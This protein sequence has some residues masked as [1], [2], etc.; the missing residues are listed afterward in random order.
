MVEVLED[1]ASVHPA[2]RAYTFIDSFGREEATLTFGELQARVAGLAA[3]LATR[4]APGQRALLIF[5]TCAEFIVTFLACLRAGVVAVPMSSPRRGRAAHLAQGIA[6]RSGAAAVLTTSELL[7]PLQAGLPLESLQWIASDVQTKALGNATAIQIN[8]RFPAFLQFTSGSTSSPKGVMVDHH[9]LMANQEVMYQ[10]FEH[11]DLST[12]VGWAPLF[13]DQGL[14]GNVL[15]PMFAGTTCVLMAPLA[16]VKRPLAWLKAISDHRA[17]TSGGPNFAFDLC[18]RQATPERLR[19]LALDLSCWTVAFNGAEPIRPDTIDRFSRT[20]EPYG[21]RRE[22]FMPCY[23]LAEGTLYV[24]GAPKG[25]GPITRFV[26]RQALRSGQVRSAQPDAAGTQ[27]LVGSGMARFGVD[28]RIVDPLTRTCRPRGQVGE[29]WVGGN[30]VARGYW[31]DHEATATVF[32]VPL[33][34]G[35]GAY[36]RTGDLGFL[37]ADGELFVTGRIKDLIIVMGRNHYPQDIERSMEGSH[38]AL[39]AGA[40]VA[41]GVDVEGQERL[42]LVQELLRDD[43]EKGG[44]DFGALASAIRRAVVSN[45]DLVPHA[46]GL[47]KAGTIPKTTSGKVQRQLLRQW[48]LAG[49]LAFEALFSSTAPAED[50]THE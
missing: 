14:I 39:R 34:D 22:A 40:G 23:G 3:H 2:R 6:A 20:F 41:F 11:N 32:Q 50:V 31:T 19:D 35:T 44:M 5:P 24:T 16:F 26:E 47:V 9:N 12:V 18:V 17:R 46:I 10:A 27:T 49:E 43:T 29:I 25:R 38:P 45:H 36:L 21:F 15:H 4:L 13:H 1:R 42:V 30:S 28:V 7:A 37:D 33:A 48:Y 8:P